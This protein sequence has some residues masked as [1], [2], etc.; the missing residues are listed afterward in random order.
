MTTTPR[1]LPKGLKKKLEASLASLT[2]RQAARLFLIYYHEG[3]NKR[4]DASIYP[5]IQ[6]LKAALQER[7]KKGKTDAD[8]QKQFRL[9][10]GFM[11]FVMLAIDA[12]K[13]AEEDFWRLSFRALQNHSMLASLMK[14]DY[15]SEVVKNV[16]KSIQS[17]HIAVRPAD[18]DRLIEWAKTTWL[19]E[20][21]DRDLIDFLF[22]EDW[23]ADQGFKH[24]ERSEYLETIQK[25]RPEEY[26]AIFTQSDYT[27][28]INFEVLQKNA[29]E[30][31]LKLRRLYTE[32]ARDRLLEEFKGRADW[33]EDWVKDGFL[34]QFKAE[35]GLR[36]TSAD[37]DAKIKATIEELINQVKAGELEGGQAVWL[38]SEVMANQVLITDG[39]VP[40]WAA[41]RAVWPAWLYDH[42]HF[43]KNDPTFD[44]ESFKDDDTAVA[45][46]R[47]VYNANGNV[48]GEDLVTLAAEFYADCKAKP[49]GEGLVASS[50]VD[51]KRLGRFLI[52][53]ESDLTEL[54]APDLGRVNLTVFAEAEANIDARPT[55]VTTE[56]SIGGDSSDAIR[57]AYY[58][59]LEPGG[60]RFRHAH[61]LRNLSRLRIDRPSFSYKRIAGEDDEGTIGLGDIYGVEFL[62]PLEEEV[63][64]FADLTQDVATL[65]RFAEMIGEEYFGGLSILI[66]SLAVKVDYLDQTIDSAEDMVTGWLDYVKEVAP[67][68]DTSSLQ[69]IRPPADEEAARQKVNGTIEYSKYMLKLSDRDNFDLGPDEAPIVDPR[70][71]KYVGPGSGRKKPKRKTDQ[72]GDVEQW[73]E[74]YIIAEDGSNEE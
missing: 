43:V 56:G 57:A 19:V 10:N 37:Y 55:W 48:E 11:F 8:R 46:I 30:E 59:I 18:Y 4:I 12:N 20:L 70:M 71:P 73:N 49:W 33:I 13:A 9:F 23:V 51:F 36:F 44:E 53:I 24:I 17:E 15:T 1:R 65:K 66:P 68:V 5:P 38:N 52:E 32:V 42:D 25:E 31:D 45:G 26:K 60:V 16:A 6:E 35:E 72:G 61:R 39:R 2:P 27:G 22:V 21:E 41:L 34:F 54:T 28:P 64:R 67:K 74:Y 58:P 62:T 14:D 63:K 40:A 47:Q 50:D 29:E 7:I 3:E 69:M